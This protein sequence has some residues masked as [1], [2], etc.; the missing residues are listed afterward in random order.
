MYNNYDFQSYN[1]D[2]IINSK[3][4]DVKIFNNYK[5]EKTN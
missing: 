1:P 2:K 3:S 4:N 5:L